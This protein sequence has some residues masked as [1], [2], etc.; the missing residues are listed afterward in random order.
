MG[1]S[2][3]QAEELCVPQAVLASSPSLEVI[4]VVA[5]VPHPETA[6]PVRE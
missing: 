6:S 3:A 4:D 5:R 1:L 2:M